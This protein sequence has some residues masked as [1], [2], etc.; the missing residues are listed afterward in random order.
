MRIRILLL[1]ITILLISTGT[2]VAK[3][4]TYEDMQKQIDEQMKKNPEAAKMMK[5]M[6]LDKQLK[7]TAEMMKKNGSSNTDLTPYMHP[8]LVPAKDNNKIAQVPKKIMSDTEL[9]NYLKQVQTK[10]NQKLSKQTKDNA[11]QIISDIRK[12]YKTGTN[13]AI[14]NAANGSWMVKHQGEALYIMGVACN[15]N[16]SD[17]DNLS[18]YAAFLTMAGAPDAAIPILIKLNSK[19]PNNS[20]ILNNL[21]QAWFDLGDTDEAEKNL[22]GAIKAFGYHSQANYTKA[23]IEESKGNKGAAIAAL[24]KSLERSY[25][26]NRADK[27]AKLGGKLDSKPEWGFHMPQDAL[28]LDNFAHPPYPHSVGEV[29]AYA[30]LWKE[31]KKVCED[32]LDALNKQA[33]PIHDRLYKKSMAQAQKYKN[34]KTATDLYNIKLDP[35]DVEKQP[36]FYDKAMTKLDLTVG[37]GSEQRKKEE[38]F[39]KKSEQ[40]NADVTALL[41][42]WEKEAKPILKAYDDQTGEGMPNLDEPYC[43]QLTTIAD[44]YIGLINAKYEDYEVE[45]IEY[46]RKLCNNGAYYE[47]YIKGSDDEVELMKIQY[48]QQF[49]GA[50]LSMPVFLDISSLPC[51]RKPPNIKKI[52]KLA[53]FYDLHCE[54]KTE[55]SFPGIGTIKAECNKL[56]MDFS[57]GPVSGTWKENLDTGSF[58][59]TAEIGVSKGGSLDYGPLSAEVNASAGGFAEFDNSGITDIGL[60]AGVSAGSSVAGQSISEIGAESRF[61]WN[62]GIS[63][64]GS[65]ILSDFSI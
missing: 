3:P 1:L 15:E 56:T 61:G 65:G 64:K 4:Q 36:P 34:V 28:G 37:D 51:E 54:S 9:K 60:K 62:S 55:M 33:Q 27:L 43:S 48:K 57:A 18:N 58:K 32:K 19:Y 52:G 49:I 23:I 11:E 20:T 39:R 46:T 17:A 47:Q 53:D 42:Q 45:Y 8:S 14:A 31:F 44:K 13:M 7:A 63:T 12:K 25:N 21:G 30:P 40:I 6:G 26:K 29:D 16:P 2:A 59:G 50:L 38:K 41:T 22:D 5:Q 10:V 24:K 35:T